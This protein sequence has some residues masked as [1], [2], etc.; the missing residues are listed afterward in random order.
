MKKV[1]VGL[2]IFMVVLGIIM[3]LLFGLDSL[4]REQYETAIIVGDNTAW[5]YQKKKWMRANTVEQYED[6]NWK[7]YHIYENNEKV[8]IYNLWHSDRWYAFDDDKNAV[9]IGGEM[10]AYRSNYDIKLDMFTKED[11]DTDEYIEAVLSDN[12]LPLDSKFTKSYKTIVDIDHDGVDEVFYAISNV[13]A[14]DFTPEKTFSFVFMVKD[15]SIYYLYE[16][17]RDYKA[18]S[19]CSPE[20]ISF[21]DA[22]TDHED[23][24]VDEVIVSCFQYSNLGRIDMLYYFDGESFKILVS[25]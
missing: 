15:N 2:I 17:V 18:Y 6:L 10:L 11:V 3:F 9:N 21:M 8:G 24:S 12:K 13:F 5:I 14:L 7:K 23:T 25:N 1:Y 22:D 16:D 4:K 20:I 19:G